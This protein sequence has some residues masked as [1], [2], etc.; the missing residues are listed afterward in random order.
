[1][2]G[3]NDAR[4]YATVLAIFRDSGRATAARWYGGAIGAGKAEKMW[5]RWTVVSK[6][7]AKIKIKV[8]YVST[9]FNDS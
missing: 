3:S 8:P 1:M 6:P 2:P 9:S 5:S 7:H 4:I